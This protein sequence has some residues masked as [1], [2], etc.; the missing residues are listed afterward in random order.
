MKHRALT[1][2][3]ASPLRGAS[4]VSLIWV[5]ILAFIAVAAIAVAWFQASNASR[6]EKAAIDSKAVE[7]N[8]LKVRDDLNAKYMAF[9]TKAGYTGGQEIGQPDAVDAALASLK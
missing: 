3:V 1:H 7:T 5:I 8:A 2:R 9:S 6:Q 4:Q